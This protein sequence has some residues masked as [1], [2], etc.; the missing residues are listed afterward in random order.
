[1]PGLFCLD[2]MQQCINA[3]VTDFVWIKLSDLGLLVSSLGLIIK[4]YNR[5]QQLQAYL[6]TLVSMFL[7]FLLTSFQPQLLHHILSLRLK[8]AGKPAAVG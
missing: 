5:R 8:T 4:Y 6:C 2:L 3:F 7:K 1:M